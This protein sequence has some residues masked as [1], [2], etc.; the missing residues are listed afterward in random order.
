MVE[1]KGTVILFYKYIKVDDPVSERVKQRNWMEELNMTGRM[2]VS[3]EGIN[4]NLFGSKQNIE[5]YKQRMNNSE[6]WRGINYKHT[7]PLSFE[8]EDPFGGKIKIRL[9]EEITG[10]GEM[11]SFDP[12]AFGGRAGIHL[13]PEKFHEFLK[14]SQAEDNY[15]VI[16]TRNHYETAAGKFDGAIDPKLRCFGQFPNWLEAN[17]KELEG[18]KVA[19]YCTGG[20]R[21]E[22]A[23]SYVKS[24]GIAEEVYQ[25]K[26]GIHN[27][28]THYS[29]NAGKEQ[30]FYTD[31]ASKE[32][33]S[34]FKKEE[35][36]YSGTN[37]QFDERYG[38]KTSGLGSE[39]QTGRCCYCLKDGSDTLGK[40]NCSVC[41]DFFVVCESCIEK[42]PRVPAN[43]RN[44]ETKE[45]K[46]VPKVFCPEHMLMGDEYEMY[47]LGL[48]ENGWG[49][50][51]LDR[52]RI[53]LINLLD[54]PDYRPNNGSKAE[55]S[56][57]DD[58]LL[59]IKHIE[60]FQEKY[61]KFRVEDN[62]QLSK[63]GGFIPF[64]PL[65][66]P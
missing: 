57:K 11:K 56:R 15:V 19:L 47:L 29:P 28:L 10:T 40:V 45:A 9:S 64:V 44:S 46:E 49:A 25:L 3:Q 53:Q 62:E 35:C 65:L 38:D 5:E 63:T 30:G 43:K 59:Q 23:S 60:D 31:Y 17:K 41:T 27:Y 32:D 18:K 61:P 58:L 55:D 36:L 22:K 2:R 7:N 54:V 14:K 37:F 42:K 33:K 26:D 21:C 13:E 39:R 48:L 66:N 52:T 16:D 12:E 34:S 1:F 24:L 4:A 20:I 8:K 50:H 51:E 6:L